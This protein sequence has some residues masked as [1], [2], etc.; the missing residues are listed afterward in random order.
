M[1]TYLVPVDFSAT[2]VNAARFAARLSSQTDVTE[3]ILLHSYYVSV[4]ESVLPTPDMMIVNNEVIDEEYKQKAGQLHQLKHDLYKIVRAGVNIRAMISRLPLTRAIIETI[5]NE[6]ADLLILGSNGQNGNNDSH[7]GCNVINISRLS[8]VPVIVVPAGA[9]YKT[10]EKVVMACDFKKVTET[11]PLEPLKRLLNQHR[12]DLEIVNIDKEAK[13]KSTSPGYHAEETALY[14]MLKEYH[15]KYYFNNEDDII[16]G[17][18]NFAGKHHSQLVIALPHKYSF[19]QNI[20]HNSVSC[21][22]SVQSAIPVL[23]LK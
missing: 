8:P 20:L 12:V 22:L 18:L 9:D 14:S 1:K 17:I 13:H 4:Y 11:M 19:F 3:I 7:I 5:A 21:K 2:S 23:L 10:I 16:N 6:S 15:P